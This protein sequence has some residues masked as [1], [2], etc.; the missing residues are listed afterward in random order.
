LKNYPVTIVENKDWQNGIASSIKCGVEIILNVAPGT[1]GIIFMVCDQPFLDSSLL[2][3]LKEKQ[4]RTDKPVVGSHYGNKTGTPALF[5][6]T[7]FP[8]LLKLEGDNGAGKLIMNNPEKVAT[9]EFPEGVFDIDTIE[10][11]N[12]IQH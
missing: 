5:H 12:K 3:E 11:Y 10:D 8:D 9:V 4:K 7:I 1:D 2:T 6:K